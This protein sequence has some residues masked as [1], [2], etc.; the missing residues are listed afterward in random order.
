M[1]IWESRAIAWT[2]V[3]LLTFGGGTLAACGDGFGL[4]SDVPLST[5]ADLEATLPTQDPTARSEAVAIAGEVVAQAPLIDAGLYRI[6]DGT[7]TL[8]IRTTTLP[9]PAMGNRLRVVFT[10]QYRPIPI[11]N[12]PFDQAFGL[13]QKRSP[14]DASPASEN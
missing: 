6:D 3:G 8:W 11:E 1:M 5:V 9:L 4:G 14:L 7:G 10:P 2:T 13:E 12:Q